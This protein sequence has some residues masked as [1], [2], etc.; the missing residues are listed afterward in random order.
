[1]SV[2]ESFNFNSDYH[3]DDVEAEVRDGRSPYPWIL[4]GIVLAKI[5]FLFLGIIMKKNRKIKNQKEE[6]KKL[7]GELFEFLV[8]ETSNQESLESIA[9]V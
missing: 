1:M 8:V 5:L 3:Q 7:R 6:I 9:D 4:L 2:T